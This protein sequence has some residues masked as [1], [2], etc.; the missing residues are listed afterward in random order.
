MVLELW[1]AQGRVGSGDAVHL[2]E[3]RD[4]WEQDHEGAPASGTR[5]VSGEVFAWGLGG[6]GSGLSA[7]LQEHGTP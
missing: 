1:G 2:Q 5:Q 7:E 6:V 3:A 4:S